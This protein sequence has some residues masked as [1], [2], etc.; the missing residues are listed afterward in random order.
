MVMVMVCSLCRRACMECI[1]PLPPPPLYLPRP[2][3]PARP[4]AMAAA[5]GMPAMP[6]RPRGASTP[7]ALLASLFAHARAG[8]GA[9][10]GANAPTR[11]TAG[12]FSPAAAGG[13]GGAAPSSFASGRVQPQGVPVPAA[14]GP[15]PAAAPPAAQQQQQ[16]TGRAVATAEAEDEDD[17]AEESGEDPELQR[18]LLL[19]WSRWYLGSPAK[20]RQPTASAAA[21]ARR[22]LGGGDLRAPSAGMQVGA[23]LS[24]EG[25]ATGVGWGGVVFEQGKQGGVVL[26]ATCYLGGVLR[27][28]RRRHGRS[29]G[30]QHGACGGREA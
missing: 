18:L 7:G 12:G 27:R 30:P 11:P 13:D 26:L 19:A 1:S 28:A 29:T 9:A 16:A 4:Q 8:G 14:A 23:S 10:A 22:L 17:E 20:H 24:R 5:I 15:S 3:W 21:A 2:L 25:A 6:D